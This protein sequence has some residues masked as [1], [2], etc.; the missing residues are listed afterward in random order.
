MRVVLTRLSQPWVASGRPARHSAQMATLARLPTEARRTMSAALAGDLDRV[1]HSS[2]V[3]EAAKQVGAHLPFEDQQ[4][5]VA[6]AYLHDIGRSSALAATGHHGL[7][8]A[9]HLV[10]R[11]PERIVALVAH[12][13]EARWEAELRGLTGQLAAFPREESIITDTLTYCDMTTG[14]AGQPISL[15]DRFNDVQRRYGSEH[16]VCRSL[17]LARPYIEA[18]VARVRRELLDASGHARAQ[19]SAAVSPPAR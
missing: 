17:E 9:L 3:A 13:S 15:D 7:D 18:A 4:V 1:R 16:T 11:F 8:G 14:L 19:R 5:L 2:A 12:H 6:S 10:G